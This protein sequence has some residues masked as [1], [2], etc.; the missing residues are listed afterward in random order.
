[1]VLL[2]YG[3]WFA[4]NYA[5]AVLATAAGALIGWPFSAILG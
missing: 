5:V 4:G 1:M 3:G 2:S